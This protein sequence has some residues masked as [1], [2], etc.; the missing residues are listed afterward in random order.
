MLCVVAMGDK[1]VFCVV[2]GESSFMFIDPLF[3]GSRSLADV[4]M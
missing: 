1:C 3:K 4:C 2:G